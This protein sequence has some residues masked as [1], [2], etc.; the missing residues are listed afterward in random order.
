MDILSSQAS[1]IFDSCSICQE[2]IPNLR[3]PLRLLNIG[4]GVYKAYETTSP[5][6][7]SLV[8]EKEIL[9]DPE[10][11]LVVVPIERDGGRLTIDASV[12]KRLITIQLRIDPC[13]LW[14]IARR[15]D[16][17]HRID[18]DGSTSYIIATPMSMLVWR[19]DW[20][21]GSA[22]GLF[23]ER[24]VVGFR[25]AIPSLLECFASQ[26]HS[27]W[28]LPFVVCQATC[29]H[30][31]QNIE[32]RE[33]HHIHQ[34]E[35]TTAFGPGRSDVPL[36]RHK[37]EEIMVGLRMM[38]DTHVNL[39]NKLRITAMVSAVVDDIITNYSR[40]AASTN[41][42]DGIS[43][44]VHFLKSR[45]KAYEGYVMYLKERAHQMSNVLFAL[46]T[47]EDAAISTDM[48]KSSHELAEH[49]AYLAARAKQDSS[50]MKTITVITMAFLPGTFFATLFAL[51]TL[52]WKGKTIVT[53]DFWVYWAF[54]LSTTA[55][56]FLLWLITTHR[57]QLGAAVPTLFK[58]RV[59][60]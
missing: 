27:P 42:N 43:T 53:D 44:A 49:S 11:Q 35:S 30:L 36:H 12:L 55:L 47:H 25:A 3:L 41:Q 29:D 8:Q 33:L 59:E 38:A 7:E 19:Y 5:E 9:D 28:L 52:D 58:N 22:A 1:A 6:I 37:T 31:D 14:F 45:V 56:V 16:G 20:Q 46:L 57:A 39:S 4:G 2:G 60:K 32:E 23:F 13:V 48:A 51:P 50:A 40:V 21:R 34:L 18:G 17:F 10:V 15:Y 24:G 26:S 54:T